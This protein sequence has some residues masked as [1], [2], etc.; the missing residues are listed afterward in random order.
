MS[1]VSSLIYTKYERKNMGNVR[2]RRTGKGEREIRREEREDWEVVA[3]EEGSGRR[4]RG[5]PQGHSSTHPSHRQHA[6]A[7]CEQ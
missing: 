6:D 3:E 1:H 2:D 5:T 7:T 4:E